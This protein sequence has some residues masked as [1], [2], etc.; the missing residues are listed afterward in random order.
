MWKS[1]LIPPGF[2]SIKEAI[3][4]ED[5]QPDKEYVLDHKELLMMAVAT[6]IDALAVGIAFAMDDVVIG[7]ACPVIGL[8]TFVL[9]FAGVAVG[10]AVGSKFQSKAQIAGG[11]VLIFIG[12]K[13][14]AEHLGWL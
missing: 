4:G 3:K 6:S 13:I 8:T 12:I 14:L 1:A 10:N 9:S 5:E 11:V 2:P 7:L